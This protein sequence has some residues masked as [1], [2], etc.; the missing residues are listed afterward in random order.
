MAVVTPPDDM[1][2]RLA[3]EG[4]DYNPNEDLVRIHHPQHGEAVFNDWATVRQHCNENWT[5]TYWG[6]TFRGA[7]VIFDANAPPGV[8]YVTAW[9][10]PNTLLTGGHDADHR[11]N[12]SGPAVSVSRGV[13]RP[14]HPKRDLSLLSR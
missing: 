8:C 5:R 4:I 13:E 2:L 1:K 9:H 12:S 14:D 10:N 3:L 6:P 11:A 7:P